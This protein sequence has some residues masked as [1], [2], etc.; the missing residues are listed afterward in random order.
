MTNIPTGLQ[1]FSVRHAL[2]DD[3]PGTIK[4]A[5]GMGYDGVEFFGPPQHTAAELKAVLDDNG[6]VC[7]GWHV[8]F[9][10]MQDDVLEETVAFHKALDNNKLIVP[11]IP[12]ELRQSRDDWLKLA[13]FF[14]QLA[15]KLAEHDM[16]TGYHNHHI[17][18]QPLDGEKPWDTLFGNTRQE[19]SMQLDT[20]N[21][22]SGGGDVLEI[23]KQY[24]GRSVTVHLKPFAPSLAQ[25]DR[26]AGFR[27]LIGEDE[28]DWPAFLNACETIGGTE[29]YIIE[30]ESD[31][32]PPLEAVDR[33]LQA[34]RSLR[35]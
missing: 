11:G 28:T 26:H 17:E 15:G 16:I 25:A 4:A 20:G 31:A 5:A 1:L 18:F 29:W 14:N 19:V 27:P 7:C 9:N 32:Y 30:Y 23:V 35:Q 21:A 8:P 2:A 34:L 13:D 22:I 24:P 33:C 10:L 3:M 6:I 12:A